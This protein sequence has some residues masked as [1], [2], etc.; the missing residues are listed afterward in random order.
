[1][2][3]I[4]RKVDEADDIADVTALMINLNIPTKGCKTLQ[5]MTDRICENLKDRSE[6]LDPNKVMLVVMNMSRS[7]VITYA[8]WTT[9]LSLLNL[10]RTASSVIEIWSRSLFC[11]KDIINSKLCFN[12][13]YI[14]EGVFISQKEVELSWLDRLLGEDRCLPVASFSLLFTGNDIIVSPTLP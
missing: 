4:K 13:M 6:N 12:D 10:G 11:N 5:Q 14:T 9:G 3:A 8:A 2:E 7:S 1:M